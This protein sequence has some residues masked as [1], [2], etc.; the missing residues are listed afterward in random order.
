VILASGDWVRIGSG[1]VGKIVTISKVSAFVDIQGRPAPEN[2]K[3]FLLSELTRIDPPAGHDTT[4][5]PPAPHS[6]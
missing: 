2:V 1:E 3:M 6:H 5:S 4:T